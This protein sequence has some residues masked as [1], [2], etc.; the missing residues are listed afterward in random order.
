MTAGPERWVLDAAGFEKLLAFLDPDRDVAAEKYE[1]VRRRLVKLLQ[2]RGCSSADEYADRAIDRVARRL[3]EGAPIDVRDPYQYFHGV[4]INVLREY[5][6]EPAR[7]TELEPPTDIAAE[8]DQGAAAERADAEQYLSRL[9]ECLDE[10]LPAQRRLLLIYHQGSGQ[11]AR[12][13]ALARE[14]QIPINALRIR[15]HRLRQAV[16]ACVRKGLGSPSETNSPTAH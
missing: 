9:D 3:V 16:E 7:K 5:W 10:L 1:D 13:Q 11:I 6:R 4:A 12:R 2:W 8:V 14:L 15:V